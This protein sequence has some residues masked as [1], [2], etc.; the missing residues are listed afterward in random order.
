MALNGNKVEILFEI[1]TIIWV[2]IQ[3][4][5]RGYFQNHSELLNIR[6]NLDHFWATDRTMKFWNLSIFIVFVS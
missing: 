2:V 5:K 3:K 1:L 6:T 4:Q